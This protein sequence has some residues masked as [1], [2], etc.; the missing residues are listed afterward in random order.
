MC[1]CASIYE[2]A[3]KGAHIHING[4]TSVCACENSPAC[5]CSCVKYRERQ[6]DR[7]TDE[8]ERDLSERV[9]T[10]GRAGECERDRE[11][12]ERDIWR[13]GKGGKG[14]EREKEKKKDLGDRQ[15]GGAHMVHFGFA[16][17]PMNT[18]VYS[19]FYGALYAYALEG[20][21]KG[22][23]GGRKRGT[24]SGGSVNGAS[25]FVYSLFSQL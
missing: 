3:N 17:R 4:F 9:S 20:M 8:A 7:Q 25:V 2:Y 5:L 24:R 1:K 11:L 16:I 12:R 14:G 19:H 21:G 18:V 13:G 10:C 22:R 6:T 15:R 23:R